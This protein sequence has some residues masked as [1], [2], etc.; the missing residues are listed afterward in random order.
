LT[1]LSNA[2]LDLNGSAARKVIDVLAAKLVK[3]WG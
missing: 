1:A 3:S 2:A